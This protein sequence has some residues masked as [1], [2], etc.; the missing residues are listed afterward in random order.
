MVRL[1]DVESTEP[2]LWARVEDNGIGGG[3]IVPGGG[4]DGIRSRI[5]AAGGTSTFVSPAGGPTALE[6][7]VPCAF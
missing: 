6:V 7:S 5:L 4:L 3:E 2:V 1:R